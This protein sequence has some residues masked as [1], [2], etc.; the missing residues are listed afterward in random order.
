MLDLYCER[1]RIKDGHRV[2]DLGCGHGALTMHVARKYKNCHVTEIT[3]S[4]SQKEYIEEQCKN[5]KLTNV[6]IKLAD[7]TTHE[8]EDRYDRIVA[9]GL[10]EWKTGRQVSITILRV[11]PLLFTAAFLST[12]STS[13]SPFLALPG[14]LTQFDA[15]RLQIMND[16]EEESRQLIKRLELGRVPDDEIRR[17]IRVEL[18]KRLRLGHSR[19]YEQQTA[20]VVAFTRCMINKLTNVD[21]K[22]ADIATHEMEDRYDRIIA[23]GLIEHM[24]N[25]ELLLRKLSKWMTPDGLLFI[26]YL[27]HKTFA[28]NFEIRVRPNLERKE[29]A[30]EERQL[31]QKWSVDVA[32][33][34]KTP[35]GGSDRWT[36]AAGGSGYE[37]KGDVELW[38][39]NIDDNAE[40][41][42][43]IMVSHSAGSVEA[44]AKQFELLERS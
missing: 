37:R 36:A 15:S 10:F 4:V 41:V 39:K 28:Y 9:I 33:A 40:A 16:K 30:A 38:L 3:Y 14:F 29:K 19:T 2:L 42:K 35:V 21:I 20:D 31:R 25:Y 17:L 1:S 11:S 32:M 44:A 8:M 13:V 34:V 18:D 22:L 7:I 6:D 43:E 26:D 5:N 12:T 24:K 23:I 27:C